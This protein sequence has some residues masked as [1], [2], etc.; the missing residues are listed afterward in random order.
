MSW[1]SK[2]AICFPATRTMSRDGQRRS[3]K[4]IARKGA[5]M[6]PLDN[7]FW[8]ALDG[9]QRDLS[10]GDG[11]AR[12]YLPGLATQAGV[13]SNSAAAFET[14][15]NLVDEGDSVDVFW[16]D[17]RPVASELHAQGRS[18]R[19]R[20]PSGDSWAY[21]RMD[22]W[23]RWRANGRTSRDFARSRPCAPGRRTGGGATGVP[24]CTRWRRVVSRRERRRSCT[25]RAATTPRSSS[26]G[27]SGSCREDDSW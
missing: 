24:S 26:T 13:F 23:S 25:C 5:T 27:A 16:T 11:L 8:S 18:C 1:F 12:R 9:P 6:H 2:P 15:T 20:S 7:P 14:L 19:A 4:P 10:V 17:A 21:A 22:A 3:R